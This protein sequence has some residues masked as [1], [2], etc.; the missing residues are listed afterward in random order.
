M[1]ILPRARPPGTGRRPARLV[2]TGRLGAS[3]RVPGRPYQ[4]LGNP[5]ILADIRGLAQ[6]AEGAHS[7]PAAARRVC[8]LGEARLVCFGSAD[9][10]M[11][12]D[13]MTVVPHGFPD[14]TSPTSNRRI[15]DA[16]ITGLAPPPPCVPR[17][18]LPRPES[19][20][21]G[22]LSGTAHPTSA[23]TW[24][25]GVVFGGYIACLVDQYAGL[26]MLSVL[27]DGASFLT[28]ST[29]IDA[30]RPMRPGAATI[31]AEVARLTARDATVEVTVSQ[32][33]RAVSLAS[34][35]QVIGYGR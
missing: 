5:L 31:S 29:R 12:G 18:S 11:P 10:M 24:C 25:P 2:L 34:I 16:I 17:F 9:H 32:Q 19:W 14:A 35:R 33:G 28:A 22:T 23:E 26:V 4:G 8:S 30:Q 1:T 15:L 3:H 13:L 21:Y 20:S 7:V 6:L 27:P